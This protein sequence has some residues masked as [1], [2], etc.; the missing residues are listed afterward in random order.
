MSLFLRNES[1]DD[2]LLCKVFPASLGNL[3]LIW[4]NQLPARSISSFDSLCDAFMARFVTS[5]KHEK[6]IDSLLALRKRNDETLR[7]YAGRYWELFNEIKGC[8][9]L[10]SARGFKLGLTPQD[11]QLIESK[12][13]RGMGKPTSSKTT[14][15][16]VSIPAPVSVSIQKKQINIMQAQRKGPKPNDFNAEKTVFTIPIYQII[17]QVK[18]QP[19]FSFPN[20][21]LGTE[22]GKI[23]NPIVRCSYHNEQGHFTTACKPFKS[24]LE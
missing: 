6:E 7:Q 15:A 12:A 24:Y 14:S 5:N 19:F 4:F 18:D 20:Q 3:G 9:G 2:A 22:N 13:E 10:I 17:D 1:S 21:K 8:D 11:E 23:K 16:S